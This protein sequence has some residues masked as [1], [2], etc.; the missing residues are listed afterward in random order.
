[1]TPAPLV[2]LLRVLVAVCVLGASAAR[3][4][5]TGS[6]AGRVFDADSGEPI[7]GGAWPSASSLGSISARMRATKSARPSR[8]QS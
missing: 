3:A 7:A 8:S 2:A 5:G 4:Q 6:V 1:M